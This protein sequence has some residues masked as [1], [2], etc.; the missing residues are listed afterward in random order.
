M[1]LCIGLGD[2]GFVKD[3]DIWLSYR[4]KKNVTTY[5]ISRQNGINEY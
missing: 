3:C 1:R 5:K 2:S 4:L